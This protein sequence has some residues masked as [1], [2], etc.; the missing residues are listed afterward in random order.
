VLF[1]TLAP[2]GSCYPGRMSQEKLA[3]FSILLGLG[4]IVIAALLLAAVFL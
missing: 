2:G 4:L 3:S 1:G